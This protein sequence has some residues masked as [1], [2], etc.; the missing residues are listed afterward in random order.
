MR[1]ETYAA[2]RPQN[3]DEVV[4]DAAVAHKLVIELLA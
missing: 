1:A 3:S 4:D 2:Q